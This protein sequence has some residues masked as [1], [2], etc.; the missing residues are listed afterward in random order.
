[1]NLNVLSGLLGLSLLA[2][3]ILLHGEYDL[4][5]SN[6]LNQANH[7]QRHFPIQHMEVFVC[8]SFSII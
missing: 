4:W 8:I 1:M 3:D 6:L 2:D 5:N 7:R